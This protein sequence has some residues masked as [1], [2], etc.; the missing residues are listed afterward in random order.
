MGARARLCAVPKTATRWRYS[1]GMKEPGQELV[2]GS[3]NKT[4]RSGVD[5][6]HT[7]LD[8]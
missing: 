5:T 7:V 1:L 3:E 4:G 8:L 6:Q 2:P